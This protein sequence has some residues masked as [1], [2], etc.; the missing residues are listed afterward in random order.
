[1]S[2]EP[3]TTEDRDLLR[4][5]QE[6]VQTR[7]S[8]ISPVGCA[9]RTTKG[10][11]YVG[12]SIRSE[13]SRPCSTCAEYPA[14]GA[15][16]TAGDAEIDTIVSV[17]MDGRIKSPCG[18]CRELMRLFGNPYV[19]VQNGTAVK[20]QLD[21]LLPFAEDE[22]VKSSKDHVPGNAQ[23]AEKRDMLVRTVAQP[24]VR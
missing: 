5:A 14:I 21:V 11:I 12:L 1:M 18:R 3:L 24:P 8:D 4:R 20:V 7:G 23:D 16:H 22:N 15:M 2:L 9:L 19:I 6:L 10:E 17:H 13:A